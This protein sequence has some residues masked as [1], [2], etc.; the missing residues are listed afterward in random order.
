MKKITDPSFRYVPAVKTDLRATFR[1]V[2]R[3]QAEQRA[4]EATAKVQ[5]IRKV[6]A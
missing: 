1:R 4:R 5:P 3:E 2:R 6:K